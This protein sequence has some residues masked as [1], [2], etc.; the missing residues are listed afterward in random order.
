MAALPVPSMRIPTLAIG[1]GAAA[2][3]L[4]VPV[5]ADDARPD[6][7]TGDYLWDTI[8]KK[9]FVPAPC[10]PNAQPGR[11][12]SPTPQPRSV[13]GRGSRQT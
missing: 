11:T 2:L 4:Q 6:A 8:E 5:R 12:G 7:T 9:T 3:L 10:I 13:P 1:L